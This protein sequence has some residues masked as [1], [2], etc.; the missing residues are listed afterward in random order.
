[1]SK[2][3]M[4]RTLGGGTIPPYYAEHVIPTYA[5]VVGFELVPNQPRGAPVLTWN[6]WHQFLMQKTL[7][8]PEAH[9]YHLARVLAALRIP[10]VLRRAD[11]PLAPD[12]V[13][14]AKEVQFKTQIY[15]MARLGMAAH[16]F[17]GGSHASAHAG[18]AGGSHNS[19]AA[20]TIGKLGLKIIGS[21]LTGGG[22][23]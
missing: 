6:G 17:G 13:A 23:F 11:L 14:Q 9:F 10:I 2:L 12:P 19:S 22:F 4:Y 7:A 20:A 8:E 21:N 15:S 5:Q 1:M 18:G 3:S 16:A